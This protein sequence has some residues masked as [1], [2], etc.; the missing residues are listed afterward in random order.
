MNHEGDASYAGP[1][2]RHH[3]GAGQDHSERMPTRA[4]IAE[5]RKKNRQMFNQKRGLSLDQLMKDLDMLIYAELSVVYY[6]EYVPVFSS[7]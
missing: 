4:E 3:D 1:S 6:M 5:R 2:T 7:V